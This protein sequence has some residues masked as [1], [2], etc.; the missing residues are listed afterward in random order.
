MRQI[1]NMGGVVVM[2]R[3]LKGY[4]LEAH[5]DFGSE[6]GVLTYAQFVRNARGLRV[7]EFISIAEWLGIAGQTWWEYLPDVAPEDIAKTLCDL[8][9]HFGTAFEAVAH[10]R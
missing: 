9:V 2:N 1:S 6:V 7:G 3:E 4:H 8:I 10:L 5:L